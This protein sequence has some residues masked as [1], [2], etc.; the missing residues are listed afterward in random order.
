MTKFEFLESARN[1]HGYK[2]KYLELCN[3]LRLTDKI[4]LEYN[5]VIYNQT[6][7]KHLEG[8]CPEK[9]TKKKTTTEFIIEAIEIWGDK[10]DYSLV[11]YKGALNNVKI[12]YNGIIYE[13]RAKSHL[14]GLAPEFR[15]NNKSFKFD[16]SGINEIREFLTKYKIPFKEKFIVDQLIFDFYLLDIGYIIEYKGLHHY[17]PIEDIG[18][19]FYKSI[20]IENKIKSEYCDDN[21]INLINIKYDMIDDIY[22]ILWQSLKYFIK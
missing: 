14:N 1:I 6:I 3:K 9:T 20:C 21:Y 11:D 13:Q 8:R 5:G 22:L 2:Y 15:K 4:S 7:S 10:Y 12:I 19:D 17:E 16:N 18:Y